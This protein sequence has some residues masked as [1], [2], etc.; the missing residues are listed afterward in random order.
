VSQVEL[1]LFNNLSLRL[2]QKI[3][4]VI[5]AAVVRTE[6]PRPYSC[7]QASYK[8]GLSQDALSLSEDRKT[9]ACGVSSQQRLC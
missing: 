3:G 8:G 7:G 2:I 6:I 5:S 1:R 4:Q 9:S